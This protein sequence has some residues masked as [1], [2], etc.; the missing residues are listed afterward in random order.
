MKLDRRLALSLLAAALG[1][2]LTSCG[3]GP[4]EGEGESGVLPDHEIDGFSLTQTQEGRKLWTLSARRALIFEQADRMELDRLRIDYYD[5]NGDATSTLTAR[6]GVL[7]TRTN[8][9]EALGD[10]VVT[11]ND[12][13]VLTTERLTWN[14]LTR[15]IES[16]RFVRVTKGKDVFTG[17]GV[18][19]DPDLKNIKVK[20]G[21]KA[22]VTTPEGELVEDH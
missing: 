21:F 22:F 20:S 17:T 11:A 5:E 4:A 10:V 14:E 13:T 1:L 9:M 3:S 15:K 8:D 18:E 7:K 19:A 2:A 6:S 12:G 16:D